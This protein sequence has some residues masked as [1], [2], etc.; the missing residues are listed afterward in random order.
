MNL[1][2]AGKRA[3]VTGASQGIGRAIALELAREGAH[4]TMVARREDALREVAYQMG[5]P[6][7]GHHYLVAD[8]MEPGRPSLVAHSA[9]VDGPVDIVIHNLGGTLDVRDPL[10]PVEEWLRVWQFNVGIAVEMNN[11]LIPPMRERG[12]GRVIHVSS[13][14]AE[15]L[16]GAAP[17]ATAKAAL[18]AYVKTLARAVAPSGVVVSAVMPGAV[19]APG[20]HWDMVRQENPA[21]YADFLRHHM[22]LGR[23]G[24][25]EEIAPMVAFLCSEQASFCVGSVLGIDGGTM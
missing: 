20:G 18:N 8:L 22:A 14:S 11:A 13:I 17:Y 23:L 19:E 12:W 24:R 21:K 10:S 9:L 5:W 3:L 1:G 4:V 25:A 2:I 15:S 16:R 6:S 7:G